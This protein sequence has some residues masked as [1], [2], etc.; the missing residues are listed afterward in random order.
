MALNKV[1]RSVQ[2]LKESITAGMIS[3]PVSVLGTPQASKPMQAESDRHPIY[4]A[5]MEFQLSFKMYASDAKDAN[6]KLHKLNQELERFLRGKGALEQDL[7]IQGK[8]SK[9]RVVN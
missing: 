4:Q 8:V 6:N 2:D 9:G 1:R 5:D 7:A 3:G